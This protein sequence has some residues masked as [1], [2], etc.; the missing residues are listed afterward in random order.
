MLRFDAT[1]FHVEK[2]VTPY[3]FPPS[4]QRFSCRGILIAVNYFRGR[5]HDPSSIKVYIPQWRQNTNASFNHIDD[6][7]LLET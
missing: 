2:N 1:K 5:G 6:A 4:P 3:A 7:H